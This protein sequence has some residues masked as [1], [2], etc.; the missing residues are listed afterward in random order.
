[1]KNTMQLSFEL[2]FGNKSDFTRRT[3]PPQFA[4]PLGLGAQSKS[5][6]TVDHYLSDIFSSLFIVK[7]SMWVLMEEYNDHTLIDENNKQTKC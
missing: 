1:M 5:N 4:Y 3:T 6:K 2:L 7:I